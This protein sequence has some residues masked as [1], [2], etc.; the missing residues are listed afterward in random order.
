MQDIQTQISRL[1]LVSHLCRDI[2]LRNSVVVIF[3]LCNYLI[4]YSIMKGNSVESIQNVIIVLNNRLRF[5]HKGFRNQYD[6][7][8]EIIS[9]Y[10]Y[11]L[12]SNECKT[13]QL[14]LPENSVLPLELIREIQIKALLVCLLLSRVRSNPSEHLGEKRGRISRT[15]AG[16]PACAFE[17]LNDLLLDT[18]N[19]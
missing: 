2:R 19:R 3:F 6:L 13:S 12:K 14:Y 18:T 17:R 8:G 16:N 15:A 11:L 7:R 9:F 10:F 5:V 4:E 1:E